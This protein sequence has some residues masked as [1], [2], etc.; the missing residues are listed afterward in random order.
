MKL[1]DYAKLIGV[2]YRT[3]WRYYHAGMLDAHQMET[4]TIIVRDPW[5]VVEK[6][7][8]D[9]TVKGPAEDEVIQD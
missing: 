4:G 7:N 6:K 2:S 3:A 5:A 1:S 8:P 9:A